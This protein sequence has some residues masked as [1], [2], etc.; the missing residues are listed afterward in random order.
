M[1]I[2]LTPIRRMTAMRLTSHSGYYYAFL[3]SPTLANAL[4]RLSRT[5][6]QSTLI[7]NEFSSKV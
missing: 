3:T 4:S 6:T 7:A 2:E 1:T 5:A